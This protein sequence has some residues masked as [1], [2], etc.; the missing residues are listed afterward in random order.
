MLA[1]DKRHGTVAGYRAGCRLEC[2]RRGIARYN[3]AQRLRRY[4]GLPTSTLRPA[5]GTQRRVQALVALGW[6][7][8]QIGL[9]I[10][11]DPAFLRTVLSS[12]GRVAAS[13]ADRVAALYEELSM[14][15]PPELTKG[16]RQGATRARNHART[17]GWL[18]PL[19]WDDIDRDEAPAAKVAKTCAVDEVAVQRALSGDVAVARSLNVHER[20]DLTRRWIAAGHGAN[21]LARLTGWKVERYYARDAA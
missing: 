16:E 21:E 15:L 14:S 7:I 12:N 17:R 19:A 9:R 13:T 10:D 18:P 1:D 6:S 5:L 3:E 8:R 11:L 20:R 2:C 4:R